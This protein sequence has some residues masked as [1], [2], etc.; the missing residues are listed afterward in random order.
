MRRKEWKAQ[1]KS[2]LVCTWRN[3]FFFKVIRLKALGRRHILLE[4]EKKGMSLSQELNW[5]R[6]TTRSNGREAKGDSL[7]LGITMIQ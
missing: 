5:R 7:A 4:V 1:E 6:H 3:S 2:Y